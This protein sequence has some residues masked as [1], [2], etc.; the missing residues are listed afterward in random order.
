MG[1]RKGMTAL[2]LVI[3]GQLIQ[4]GLGKIWLQIES[5]RRVAGKASPLMH[6]HLKIEYNIGRQQDLTTV[7]EFK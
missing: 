2:V 3:A 7:P 4:R 6:F 1:D 5:G